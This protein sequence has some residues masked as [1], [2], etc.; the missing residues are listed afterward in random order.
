MDVVP[1]RKP[2]LFPGLDVAS[3]YKKFG[4]KA[5]V[6]TRT[7]HLRSGRVSYDLLTGKAG[8]PTGPWK[9]TGDG[10]HSLFRLPL[11]PDKKKPSI[12]KHE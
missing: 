3:I 8:S 4:S 1:K 7:R 10:G 2:V 6:G 11:T 12:L 5:A 9:R